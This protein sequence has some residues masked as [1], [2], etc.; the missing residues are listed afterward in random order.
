MT[1]GKNYNRIVFFT[2][3]SVYLGLVLA[4]ATPQVLSYAALTRNFD[5][6]NEIEVKD[7]LDNKPDN[8]EIESSSKED[9]PLLFVRLLNEIKAAADDG[10]VSLPLQTDFYVDAQAEVTKD[11][12]GGGRS[13]SI[14]DKNLDFLINNAINQKLR[15]KAF[16]LADYDG[17]FKSLKISLAAN[18]KDLTLKISFGK[19]NAEQFAEFLNR[20]FSSSADE[21]EDKLLKQA[22]ENSTATFENNQV[23]IVTR[24]PRAG[25]DSHLE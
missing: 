9:F 14:S 3:L 11:G 10:K 19:F 18:H 16:E 17:D 7:D 21:I 24:L 25:I 20:E 12:G 5:I 13:S 6:Q 1:K 22:Y 2:T 15:P 8:E 23:F 4:G